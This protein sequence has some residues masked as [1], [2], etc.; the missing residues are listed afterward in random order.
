GRDDGVEDF[1]VLAINGDSD[2]PKGSIGQTLAELLPGLAG[3]LAAVDAGVGA[4]LD[5][6][7]AAGVRAAADAG[8]RGGERVGL[9]RVHR[10]VDEAGLLVDELDALPGLAAVGGLVDA[11]L[12]VGRPDVA[13]G[14]DVHDLGVPGVDDD[15]GDVLGVGQAHV[16]PGLAAVGG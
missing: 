15:A 13:Q 8:G 4:E 12:L 5:L 7:V 1:R 16:L 11:A 9:R 2:S 14:G 3:V 10:Q 6:R